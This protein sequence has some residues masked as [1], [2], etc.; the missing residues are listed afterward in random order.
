MPT[1]ASTSRSPFEA[2]GHWGHPRQGWP[3]GVTFLCEAPFVGASDWTGLPAAAALAWCVYYRAPARA[4]NQVL[5]QHPPESPD[6]HH[7]QAMP[8][9]ITRHSYC[10]PPTSA[11][12]PRGTNRAAKERI[13]GLA[14]ARLDGSYSAPLVLCFPVVSTMAPF[15]VDQHR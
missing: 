1:I 15:R 4:P 6:H 12:L 9:R 10:P 2:E 3:T 11:L 14:T 13:A 8:R 5:D 7:A